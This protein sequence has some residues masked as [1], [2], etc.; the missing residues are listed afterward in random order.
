MK[1]TT[2]A[3]VSRCLMRAALVPLSASL[4]ASCADKKATS[5]TVAISSEAAIPEEI[6]EMSVEVMRGTDPHFAEV[7]PLKISSDGP[8]LPATLT[9]KPLESQNPSDPIT[10]R[11]RANINKQQVVLRTATIG[12]VEEKSKLLRLP[13]RYSCYDFPIDCGEGKSCIGGACQS[14][15]VNAAALPEVDTT[16]VFPSAGSTGCF[17]ASDTECAK[18][19]V[20]IPDLTAFT[21]AKCVFDTTG[22]GDSSSDLNVFVLWK[23]SYDQGHLTVLDQE[24]LSTLA[25]GWAY[26]EGSTSKLQ[27]ATALCDQIKAGEITKVAFNR[28][29]ATKTINTP[30]CTTTTTENQV[31]RFSQSICHKCVYEPSDCSAKLEAA[32]NETDSAALLECSFSCPYDGHYDNKDECTGVGSCFFGCLDPFLS[33]SNDGSCSKYTAL[34]AWSDCVNGLENPSTRCSTQCDAEG[35]SVCAVTP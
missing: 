33:C 25:E 8:R 22:L 3:L 28:A 35:I 19:R 5:L 34:S 31:T 24:P 17:N 1:S 30:T 13:L 9:L 7:Y 10:I 32:Q 11:I 20:N 4:L 21:D 14:N 23:K 29:C 16:D 12:F 18:D 15:A 2:L 27:L 6:D 26:A